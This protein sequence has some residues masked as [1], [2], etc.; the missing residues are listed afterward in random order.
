M[1]G[2]CRRWLIIYSRK[3][4]TYINIF[5]TFVTFS[6]TPYVL[7]AFMMISNEVWKYFEIHVCTVY[8]RA[9]HLP[10]HIHYKLL[11]QWSINYKFIASRQINVSEVPGEIICITLR[12]TCLALN[13]GPD[14]A[15]PAVPVLMPLLHAC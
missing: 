8:F 7:T 6:L 13:I 14:N 12:F 2:L 11:N 4:N 3:I 15:S 10:T 1:A 5:N 9:G